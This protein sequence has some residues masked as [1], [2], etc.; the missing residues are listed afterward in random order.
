MFRVRA[1]PQ[2]RDGKADGGWVLP[3]LTRQLKRLQRWLSRPLLEPLWRLG[4]LHGP[5]GGPDVE[6]IPNYG[7]RALINVRQMLRFW[8]FLGNLET[9]IVE[10]TIFRFAVFAP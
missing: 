8:R 1:R 4:L 10:S 3:A 6:T 7:S 5:A 9:S 2:V